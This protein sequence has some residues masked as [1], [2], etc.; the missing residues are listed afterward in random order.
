[1]CQRYCAVWKGTGT[2]TEG[3]IGSGGQINLTKT[4][5][6]VPPPIPMRT[7]PSVSFAN[8]IVSDSSV[9]DATVSSITNYN[10]NGITAYLEVVH[11]SN[12]AAGKAVNLRPSNS[13]TG[14]LILSAEL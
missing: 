8:L 11:S 5:A 6:Y 3:I 1:M 14:Y 7:S 13:T 10:Y 4:W 12:G 9:F 2:G